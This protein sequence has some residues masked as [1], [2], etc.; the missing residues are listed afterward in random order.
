[1]KQIV[2]IKK[3]LV[4]AI[5]LT[6][7]CATGCNVKKSSVELKQEV[8]KF[9]YGDIIALDPFFY[10]DGAK[11]DIENTIIEIDLSNEKEYSKTY[12]QDEKIY[13]IFDLPEG[14]YRATAR[15][16]GEILEFLIV[17]SK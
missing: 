1:M 16:N 3:E 11:K 15:R 17:V 8:Y 7:L 14:K 10:V 13:L 2:H 6:L 9:K 5:I 12:N 4:I